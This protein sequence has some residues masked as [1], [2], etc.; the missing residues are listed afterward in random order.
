MLRVATLLAQVLILRPLYFCVSS[1]ADLVGVL[2][3]SNASAH[4]KA[5]AAKVFRQKLRANASYST[6]DPDEVAAYN[7]WLLI[8]NRGSEKSR[9]VQ[10][11]DSNHRFIESNVTYVGVFKTTRFTSSSFHEA[12]AAE[13]FK[14]VRLYYYAYTDFF[15]APFS[16]PGDVEQVLSVI[17]E[18][19]KQQGYF[20]PLT[21][22][23]IAERIA[24]ESNRSRMLGG[25][26]LSNLLPELASEQLVHNKNQGYVITGRG[27]TYLKDMENRRLT[28]KESVSISKRHNLLVVL[29]VVIGAASSWDTLSAV[30]CV[31]LDYITRALQ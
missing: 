31:V 29:L 24:P 20:A 26:F 8:K 19:H 14:T 30:Y 1:F 17:Y 23:S 27:I 28:H 2:W 5:K 21:P 7:F 6:S 15:P 4:R 13:R 9:V 16:M 11:S 10:E 12:W 25:L 3:L 18:N 22:E